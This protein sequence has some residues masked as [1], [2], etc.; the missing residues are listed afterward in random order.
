MSIWAE[1]RLRILFVVGDEVAACALSAD[2][3]A[4]GF[5]TQITGTAT[6]A[7]VATRAFSPDA[8]IV[9]HRLPAIDATELIGELSRVVPDL[10]VLV[11]SDDENVRPKVAAMAAGA[12]HH[13]REPVGWP[14]LETVAREA[15]IGRA[16]SSDDAD[17]AGLR[18]RCGLG[19]GRLVG[20][21]DAMR[22]VFREARRV[23]GAR[24]NV[25]IV[26][27]SGVGKGVLARTIHDLGPHRERPFVRL[28]CAK[29]TAA[30]MATDRAGRPDLGRLERARGGT[31]FLDQIGDL[32]SAAQAVLSGVFQGENLEPSTRT[33]IAGDVRVIAA[34]HRDLAHDVVRGKFR[35]DLFYRL[36]VVR[37]DVPPLR[38]RGGDVLLL[39]QSFSRRHGAHL[40]VVG[41]DEAA[42]D[43]LVSHSWPGNVR[44]LEDVIQ[45]GLARCTSPVLRGEDLPELHTPPNVT[46]P[47]STLRDIERH[48]ILTTY[49]ATGQSAKRTATMLGMSL[50]TVQYRLRDYGLGRGRGR[51][52]KSKEGWERRDAADGN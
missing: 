25:L 15:V 40:G 48:A 44:E 26:G 18:E 49:E 35:E 13:L 5:E 17:R 19:L 52:P 10:P 7:L 30:L 27:E 28:S 38:E 46:I 47:G 22:R 2:A 24:A 23:A 50:R 9:A 43:K 31:L 16:L 45:R 6:D 12:A 29:L 34:T 1:Q 36:N 21:S 8:V 39:A 4:A 3:E 51:P 32:P 41:L 20:S 11:I 14:E 33:P 42:R 37:I